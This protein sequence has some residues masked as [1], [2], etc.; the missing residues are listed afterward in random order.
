[1]EWKLIEGIIYRVNTVNGA[2]FAAKFTG[3]SNGRLIFQSSSGI[4]SAHYPW[5]INFVK[6]LVIQEAPQ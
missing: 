1:M 6:P 5:E 4:V 2:K 3:K